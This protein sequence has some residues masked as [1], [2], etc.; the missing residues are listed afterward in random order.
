M[1]LP[2]IQRDLHFSTTSLAWV[3]N[4]YALMFGGF[5]L[6]GGRAS[7]LFGRRRLFVLGVSLFT[8]A[9]L[10][11]G[12]RAAAA[13]LLGFRAVQGLGAA[14]M[15]PASLSILTTTF[16]EGPRAHAGAGGL[17]VCQRGRAVAAACCWAGC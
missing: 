8:V 1:A 13:M 3:V 16:L 2:S 12:C 15:T 6:L 5:L 7:D 11:A 9:S 14:L 17:G 10:C 4:L